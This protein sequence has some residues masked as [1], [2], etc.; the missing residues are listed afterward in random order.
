VPSEAN[1]APFAHLPNHVPL[2][3]GA[4]ASVRA[5]NPLQKAWKEAKAEMF[6]GRMTKPDA[7]DRYTLNHLIWYE[8]TGFKRPYPGETTVRPPTAFKYRLA[9]GN[10]DLDD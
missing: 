1:F 3:K 7:E 4:K 9:R 10:G 5:L 2:D 8:A 6:A